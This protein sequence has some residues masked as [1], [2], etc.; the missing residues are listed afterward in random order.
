MRFRKNKV[1]STLH[2]SIL[3]L[4]FNIQIVSSQEGNK[5]AMRMALSE[6]KRNPQ[7]WMIDFGRAPQ[8]NYTQGLVSLAF[9]NLWEETKDLEFFNYTKGY[10]DKLID[11]LG[12]IISYRE[13]DYSL[14][15]VN[16]GKILFTLYSQTGD[17][18][19]KKAIQKL[20]VQ[21]K[22]QPRTSE[23]GFWHKKVYPHQMWLDGIYMGTPF[24]AQYG[25][26]YNDSLALNEAVLQIL[27]IQKHTFDP[28][29]GLNYHAWDESK[30][31]AWS[32]PKTGCSPH[33]WGRAQG[34]YYMAI[35]DALDYIPENF[36]N[37]NQLISIL[38]NLTLNIVKVQDKQSGV[39]YQVL[40]EG[41]RAGNYLESSAS[42]MFIYGMLKAVRKGYV[43][44][45][46]LTQAEKGYKGILKTFIRE[47]SDSTIS[48]TK[49]CT[50]AGLGGKP[51]RSGTFEYY[52]S[53]PVRD[54]DPKAVGPFILASL[55]YKNAVN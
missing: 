39:W 31:Q 30:Q 4:L 43:E 32:D 29:T 5:W 19:Y 17:S 22:D 10:A 54:D 24:L 25:S 16:S 35:V 26:I 46:F 52:I 15:K 11:S 23:G 42:S 3:I 41:T 7:A 48:I 20:R 37:R 8:W 6:M 2:T 12:N 21:L 49:G 28:K 47:N 14:D 44:R 27:T 40:D 18:R 33:V 45:S 1:F 50:V 53:E 51:Y 13:N 34:W 38:K 9:L 36:P 55:E